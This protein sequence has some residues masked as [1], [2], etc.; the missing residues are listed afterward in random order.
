MYDDHATDSIDLSLDFSQFS[1]PQTDPLHKLKLLLLTAPANLNLKSVAAT[2]GDPAPAAATTFQFAIPWSVENCPDIG[3]HRNTPSPTPG[4]GES[5]SK[6]KQ[7]STSTEAAAAE[8]AA[9]AAAVATNRLNAAFPPGW[10]ALLP[11]LRVCHLSKDELTRVLKVVAAPAT[12]PNPDQNGEQN[13]LPLVSDQN[14]TAAL[15][16][17]K[18]IIA[19][20]LARYTIADDS[21]EQWIKANAMPATA[22]A[23][24]SDSKDTKSAP[25]TAVAATATTAGA[26]VPLTANAQLAL[27]I[28]RI[29]KRM[30]QRAA[31]G[32]NKRLEAVQK[33]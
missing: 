8:A 20:N 32:V 21:L 3:K 23:T 26:T 4:D 25:T 9:E 17:I 10:C 12:R 5:D 14:E 11:F 31:A 6:Q 33:R 30:W 27:R 28:I 29:E 7:K 16:S 2:T 1:N 18:T 15:N 19:Q 13:V 22:A 24:A